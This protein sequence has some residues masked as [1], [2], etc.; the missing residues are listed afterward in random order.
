M[1]IVETITEGP[2]GLERCRDLFVSDPIGCNLV[3]TSLS[4]GRDVQ[5]LLATDVNK[6]LGAAV[7]WRDSYTLT[8]LSGAA[9]G[10]LA[11]KL[12]VSDDLRLMGS[13]SDTANVAGYWSERVGGAVETVELFRVYRLKALRPPDVAGRIVVLGGENVDLAVEWM[14]DFGHE[15]GLVV[16]QETARA[17]VEGAVSEGRLYG[18]MDADG[19]VAQLGCSAERYGVVRIGG[20][21]TPAQQR[22]HGYASALT[23][24]VSRAQ[25]ARPEVDEVTLNLRH[26]TRARIACTDDWDSNQWPN[27]W[28][29]RS[30]RR[31]RSS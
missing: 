25:R 10:L 30:G 28:L 2:V 12:P 19:L 26:Q 16:N 5:L 14:M 29:L 13:P 27:F 18:W 4:S 8:P 15:T 23:S 1:G 7:R 21:F 9:A 20:V 3:A 22:G 17:Q 31:P 24:A 11:D 6:V